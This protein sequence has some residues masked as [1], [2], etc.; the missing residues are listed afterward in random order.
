[1]RFVPPQH[2]IR[3]VIKKTWRDTSPLRVAWAAGLGK[4]KGSFGQSLISLRSCNEWVAYWSPKVILLFVLNHLLPP[5]LF[6][7]HRWLAGE[8]KKDI[9]SFSSV[10]HPLPTFAA[11]AGLSDVADGVS[12]V[13]SSAVLTQHGSWPGADLSS[14]CLLLTTTMVGTH[15]L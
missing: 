10:P 4:G 15:L 3:R 7:H 1:M 9:S 11:I 2:R 12:P 6:H 8:V 13:A 14:P 5:P